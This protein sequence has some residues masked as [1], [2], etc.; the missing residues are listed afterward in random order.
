MC[1]A[2]VYLQQSDGS[3]AGEPAFD[4]VA[5][6]ECKQGEVIITP[7][8]ATSQTI[9]GQIRSVDLLDSRVIIETDGE[10]TSDS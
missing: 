7:M 3:V 6:L 2:A 10:E 8:L 4:D 5:L 9:R 1:L